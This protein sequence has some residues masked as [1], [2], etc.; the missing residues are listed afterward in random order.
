[1][2]TNNKI[3]ASE[4]HTAGIGGASKFTNASVENSKLM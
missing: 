2:L 4:K 3:A 1:M